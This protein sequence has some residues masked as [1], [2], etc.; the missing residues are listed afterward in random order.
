M[1]Q[2]R[3]QIARFLA[4]SYVA[5]AV[6]M[7]VTV[8]TTI[9]LVRGIRGEFSD[10][11]IRTNLAKSGD[12]IRAES[13]DLINLAY[14]YVSPELSEADRAAI[15]KQFEERRRSLNTIIEDAVELT[16]PG[17][18]VER[19]QLARIQQKV[20]D[21]NLQI[22]RLISV[23]DE[24]QAFGQLTVAEMDKLISDYIEPLAQEIASFQSYEAGRV[25][26]TTHQALNSVQIILLVMVMVFVLTLGFTL[27][28]V[29][30][31]FQRIIHPLSELSAGVEQLQS[32][33][34]DW[35][36]P[37]QGNDEI[38]SLASALGGM[39]TRLKQ[40]LDGLEQNISE[41]S[42]TKEALEQSEE[43]YRG[44]FNG[45]PVGLYRTT[46]DGEF[47]NVNSAIVQLLGYPDRETLLQRNVADVYEFPEDRQYWRNQLQEGDGPQ[48]SELRIRRYDG[49]VIWVRD[50]TRVVRDRPGSMLFFEGSLEDITERKQAEADVQRLNAELERRVIERTAQLEAANRELESFSYSVSHDLRAPLRA[51]SGYSRILMEDYSDVLDETGKSYLNYLQSASNRMIAIVDDLL[52]LSQVTQ[53]EM[54]RR[55]LDLSSLA[56]DIIAELRSTEPE[57]NV[58]FWV[59]DDMQV[60]A[61]ASLMRIVLENLLGNAWKFTSKH[62]RARIDFGVNRKE[63]QSVFY[64]RD[65]GAGFDMAHIGKLFN[66]FQRLHS[67]ADFD[68][69]G[70]GLA[71]VQR[72]IQRHNGTVWAEGQVEQGATFYFTL[73]EMESS[74]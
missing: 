47:I 13:L 68:G 25:E 65:D 15:L 40:T 41:L 71:T 4:M 5:L 70:I 33:K 73:P 12:K 38:S 22:S 74:A 7:L 51:L 42:Q 35:S 63:A 9:G 19:T 14:R 24:E 39:A 11:L 62:T 60:Y 21:M 26:T 36:M 32:G 45:I 54:L 44:L 67:L 18:L 23:Y 64:V 49:R 43:H 17:D 59:A 31:S 66:A 50:A 10:A 57:R 6:L 48:F 34:L 8:V 55:P 52:K 69:T 61:D 2:L 1:R 27:I 46:W 56:R 29:Y 28:M 3:G 72:I 16:A 58:D 53:S 20:V 37:V 30:W